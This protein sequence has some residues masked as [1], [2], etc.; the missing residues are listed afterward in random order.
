MPQEKQ[1]PEAPFVNLDNE[2]FKFE[3]DVWTDDYALNVVQQ[4][5]PTFENFRQISHDNRWNTNDSLFTG[6]KDPKVWEGT[7]VPRASLGMP[8][9]FDQISSALPAIYNALFGIGPEWFQVEAEPGTDPREARAI[10]A[11]MSYIL[12]HSRDNFSTSAKTELKLAFLNMCLYGNG[13]IELGWD[14]NMKRPFIRWCDI[15]DFYIDP[16]CTVPDVEEARGIIRRK[17][18]TVDQLQQFRDVEG[19]KIPED[20]ILNSLSKHPVSALSDQTKRTQ[21]SFRSVSWQ[22]GATDY[23]STP[24]DRKIEVLMYYS[25]NRIVWVLNRVWCCYNA[26]N[27]YGFYPFAFSPCYIFP[28]RFHAMSMGDVQEGNQRY[29]E[30]LINGRLDEISLMIK[31]PRSM[32]RGNLMTPSQQRWNPGAVYQVD[33]PS[34]DM[35]LLQPQNAL[36]NVYTEISYLEQQAEKRTGITGMSQGVPKGG[37]VNRTATGVN[38]QIQGSNNRLQDLVANVEDYLIVPM[39]YKL[40]KLIQFHTQPND[41]LPAMSKYGDFAK[42]PAFVYQK[43]IKFRMNAASRMMSKQTLQQILPFISQYLLNG[44]MLGAING[45]GKTVDFNEY[46]QMMQDATGISKLYTLVRDLTPE[47]QKKMQEQQQ[48]SQ[49]SNKDSMDYQA[50]MAAIKSSGEVGHEKNQVELQKAQLSKPNPEQEQQKMQQEVQMQNSKMQ[51]EFQMKQLEFQLKQ[52]EM[53]NDMLLEQMKAQVETKMKMQMAQIEQDAQKQS[54]FMDIQKQQGDMHMKAQ[55]NQMKLRQMMTEASVNS[56]ASQQ[57]MD[58]QRQQGEQDLQQSQQQH[59][60]TISHGEQSHKQSLGHEKQAGD[61]KLKLQRA[62]QSM[63]SQKHP[64][65]GQSG[66]KKERP[67]KE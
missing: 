17:L 37:N 3:G 59:D 2:P 57:E 8:I 14:E 1:V 10:Q 24:Q 34:K 67:P 51:M 58:L 7:N 20:D 39:L 26:P 63:T 35:Q 16:G 5:F 30:A 50:R 38:T 52:K 49:Q 4:L 56:A 55:D 28:S 46:L 47:E 48:Q 40:Y 64:T 41:Q 27:P 54:N 44:Q 22:P 62:Q 9:V 21:E 32:K 31:P 61:Q 43:P 23:L 18:L 33:D 45:V 12:E 65:Y 13:G 53:E 60:Q 6:W 19:F 66:K 11:S 36:Q 15:R 29:I 42:I 25:K